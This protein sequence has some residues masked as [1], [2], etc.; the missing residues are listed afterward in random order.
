MIETTRPMSRGRLPVLVGSVAVQRDSF[1]SPITNREIYFPSYPYEAKG[2]LADGYG[3]DADY[4]PLNTSGG[5]VSVLPNGYNTRTVSSGADYTIYL[6][7]KFL[8]Q[9]FQDDV[10]NRPWIG[11][12]ITWE[13]SQTTD[14]YSYVDPGPAVLVST[15]TTTATF[16]YTFSS[17]DDPTIGSPDYLSPSAM[18]K[19]VLGTEFV[20]FSRV[21]SSLTPPVAYDD[22][23][24]TT[25]AWQLTATTP[26]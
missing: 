5:Y 9:V 10:I 14:V 11:V 23:Q 4:A 16:T 20:E 25:S 8:V 21:Y 17:A 19:E 24:T 15:T 7:P 2:Y 22:T 26:P 1:Y 18:Q 12:T 13:A 3:L 6:T